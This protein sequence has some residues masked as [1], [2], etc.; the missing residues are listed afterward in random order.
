MSCHSHNEYASQANTSVHSS[1]CTILEVMQI[2]GS[3]L[4]IQQYIPSENFE[5]AVQ[6]LAMKDWIAESRL[7]DASMLVQASM[8]RHA[9][10]TPP[11]CHTVTT[12]ALARGG[13]TV[14]G[15]GAKGV[16]VTW[17]AAEA[18]RGR[19]RGLRSLQGEEEEDCH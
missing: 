12:P 9:D 15:G 10:V 16:T 7:T 8:I 3:L 13:V 11:P 17:L 18:L 14:Q 2:F 4:S 6:C 5:P 19:E 1:R